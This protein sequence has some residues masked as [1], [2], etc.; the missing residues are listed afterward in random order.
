M[1]AG[2]VL[3][4]TH[5]HRDFGYAGIFSVIQATRAARQA[6]MMLMMQKHAGNQY[7]WQQGCRVYP[8][9]GYK[10]NCFVIEF[11]GFLI[12]SNYRSNH[13]QIG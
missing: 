10:Y 13:Q 8:P 12:A 1:L 4:M 9:K 5:G 2:V 6:A 11:I 3:Y 7:L